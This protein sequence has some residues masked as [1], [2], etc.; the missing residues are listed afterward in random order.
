M[1][2]RPNKRQKLGPHPFIDIEAEA[3]IGPEVSENE[4][5]DDGGKGHRLSHLGS[6]IYLFPDDGLD[7]SED[8]VDSL[9]THRSL[10][11]TMHDPQQ[12]DDWDSFIQ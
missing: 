2:E 10:A 1:S 11:H 12:S 3:S 5:E 6:E 8:F 7:D 9:A 4:F